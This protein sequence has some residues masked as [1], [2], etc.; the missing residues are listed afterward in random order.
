METAEGDEAAGEEAAGEEAA[1]IQIERWIEYADDNFLDD[2]CVDDFL[3]ISNRCELLLMWGRIYML[4][5]WNYNVI[6]N[7]KCIKVYK[8]VLS[9]HNN[10]FRPK[11]R[12]SALE[13]M[14]YPVPRRPDTSDMEWQSRAS[15]PESSTNFDCS[16]SYTR[17]RNNKER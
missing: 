2:I 14:P 16:T 13:L 7:A 4:L 17:P 6:A 5:W 8:Q 1:G 12:S 11:A 9:T 3:N 10:I 15:F